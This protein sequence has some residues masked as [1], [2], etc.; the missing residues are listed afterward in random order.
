MF[1][2]ESASH[3]VF[4]PKIVSQELRFKGVFLLPR[5]R[6]RRSMGSTCCQCRRCLL[7][8]DLFTPLR[9]AGI[10]FPIVYVS[11]RQNRHFS[12]SCTCGPGRVRFV[13]SQF[14]PLIGKLH[15]FLDEQPVVIL[16][17][18]A[19][20]QRGS[21]ELFPQAVMIQISHSCLVAWCIQRQT[22]I[23]Y[24][25]MNC[26]A[27]EWTGLEILLRIQ[28]ADSGATSV[29]GMSFIDSIVQYAHSSMSAKVY[30]VWPHIVLARTSFP[31]RGAYWR[32]SRHVWA[33]REFPRTCADRP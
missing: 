27:I 3:H 2:F 16:L 30:F 25:T 19:N 5:R 15:S 7:G 1:N 20:C 8:S 12:S 10:V 6:Q 4:H 31:F 9:R 21:E 23:S 32:M 14:R 26:L 24:F 29:P 13:A 28:T 11:R 17:R 33:E 18:T 22:G